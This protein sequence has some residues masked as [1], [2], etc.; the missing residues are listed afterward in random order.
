[1][2]CAQGRTPLCVH[3][4]FAWLTELT[5][6]VS[7]EYLVGKVGKVL[8]ERLC[9]KLARGKGLEFGKRLWRHLRPAAGL[10]VL[11]QLIWCP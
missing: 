4:V 6:D 2:A 9:G 8:R 10:N 1:M 11:M 3:P 7:S 5:G